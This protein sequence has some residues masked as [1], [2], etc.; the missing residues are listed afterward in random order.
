MGGSAISGKYSHQS[1]AVNF[2][3]DAPL[4]PGTT[5]EVIVPAGGVADWMGNTASTNFVSTFTTASENASTNARTANEVSSILQTRDNTKEWTLY[6]NPT[7][8]H[9]KVN[10]GIDQV[11]SVTIMNMQGVIFQTDYSLDGGELLIDFNGPN[12]LYV[13]QV[14]TDDKSQLLRFVK[15]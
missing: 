4:N 15:E 1:A 14:K 2:T 12:G 3:P 6:P 5:Y 9:L 8:G 13:I 7:S 10:I 11:E